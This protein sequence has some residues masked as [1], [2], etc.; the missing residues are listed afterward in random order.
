MRRGSSLELPEFV[1]SCGRP[2]EYWGHLSVGCGVHGCAFVSVLLAVGRY[3]GGM[4]W[5]SGDSATS[6]QG[7]VAPDGW[8]QADYQRVCGGVLFPRHEHSLTSGHW[9]SV[10]GWVSFPQAVETLSS[11]QLDSLAN[12]DDIAVGFVNGKV[13][14]LRAAESVGAGEPVAF[15]CSATKC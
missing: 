1:P 10:P 8:S 15:L 7:F 5:V 11:A 12:G 4:L 2:A 6:V 13:S 9:S 14:V 3:G